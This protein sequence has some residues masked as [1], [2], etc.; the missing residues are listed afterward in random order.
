[1]A[2]F[3]W[4]NMKDPR[5]ILITGASSGIGAALARA[6]AQPG[7]H[8]FL[9]GR[10][11]GRL[12][13][14]ARECRKSG[15]AVRT[16]V[17]E[18]TDPGGMADWIRDADRACPL[19]LVIANAGM[20]NG[21][22]EC[23]EEADALRRMIEVNL[24]G[25][26]NTICP[27]IAAMRRR[28]RGQIGLM[29]SLAA[30]RGLPGAHG[31]SATKAALKALG[32]G[33]RPSLREDGIGVTVILPGF[34]RTPMNENRGFPTPLRIEADR[35]A[36][37]IK[38]GLSRDRPVIAFPRLSFWATR[39]AAAWPALADYLALRAMRRPGGGDLPGA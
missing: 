12:E 35:A 36:A 22:S 34:V 26:V 2:T 17:L 7:A 28:R 14:V 15:A 9:S 30:L 13:D 29:S 33:L 16:A 6:Y 37:L 31:Y 5:V 32:E 8:L 18:V 23:P 19:D 39:L 27:A 38:R 25:T 4:K 10:N 20:A 3:S 1:M 24:V 11:T 21:I